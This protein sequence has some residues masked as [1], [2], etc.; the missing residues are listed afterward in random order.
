MF[1]TRANVEALAFAPVASESPE[2]S[3]APAKITHMARLK[4]AFV[5]DAESG[6]CQNQKPTNPSGSCSFSN[7]RQPVRA[8][9]ERPAIAAVLLG[10]PDRSTATAVLEASKTIIAPPAVD[11]PAA[12]PPR[13]TAGAEKP[14]VEQVAFQQKS[15]SSRGTSLI[16]QQPRQ[17]HP[18][19]GKHAVYTE[20]SDWKVDKLRNLAR[21][22]IGSRSL[23]RLEERLR[24]MLSRTWMQ[25]VR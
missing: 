24:P 2:A 25:L 20:E 13:P 6:V 17:Q 16:D 1:M 4:S 12:E 23:A 22:R 9:N 14:G 3:S 8:L 7:P 19:A 21:Q 10:Q 18:R 5:A 15:K 11:T